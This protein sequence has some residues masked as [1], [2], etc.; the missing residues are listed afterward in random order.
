MRCEASTR[1]AESRQPAAPAPPGKGGAFSRPQ[2][3][4][5]AGPK[6]RRGAAAVAACAFYM[7]SGALTLSR[8][9]A[10]RSTVWAAQHRVRRAAAS[11]SASPRT[12]Q[13]L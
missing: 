10:L 12:R 11:G 7:V 9:R 5:T 6:A 2:G 8:A 3:A 1:T 13:V 4:K